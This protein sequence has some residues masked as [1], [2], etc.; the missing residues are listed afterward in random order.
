LIF[1]ILPNCIRICVSVILFSRGVY[2][3]RKMYYHQLA[4]FCEPDILRVD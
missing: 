1:E 4:L 2:L 3:C